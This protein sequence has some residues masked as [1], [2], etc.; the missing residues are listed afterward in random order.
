MS[1]MMLDMCFRIRKD[2]IRFG[3][4]AETIT[5]WGSGRQL[6]DSRYRCCGRGPL[7]Y[8]HNNRYRESTGFESPRGRKGRGGWSS[9]EQSDLIVERAIFNITGDGEAD[10]KQRSRSHHHAPARC[11]YFLLRRVSRIETNL[12]REHDAKR[13]VE[14]WGCNWQ[15]PAY[16]WSC[17][18]AVI[19][20]CR[21]TWSSR[22]LPE[23][24]TLKLQDFPKR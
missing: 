13:G 19:I 1:D 9:D 2:Q 3:Q 20:G 17:L 5:V 4:C 8:T 6:L 16:I 10:N 7:L 11:F 22:G 21:L 15:P 23:M 18:W 12:H 14:I 24:E